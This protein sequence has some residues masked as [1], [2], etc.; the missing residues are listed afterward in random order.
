[1]KVYHAPITCAKEMKTSEILKH[2][3]E[4]MLYALFQD[5]RENKKTE[6]IIIII[7]IIIIYF[8]KLF[9]N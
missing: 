4:L 1:M 7:I 6:R 3:E 9:S 5:K 2:V 8:I